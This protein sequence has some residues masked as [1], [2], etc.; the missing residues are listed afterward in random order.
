[1]APLSDLF[2]G[3]L[4][5]FFSCFSFIVVYVLAISF[6]FSFSDLRP[7]SLS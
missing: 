5:L 1:M 6:L 2:Y 3:Y 7:L 4:D